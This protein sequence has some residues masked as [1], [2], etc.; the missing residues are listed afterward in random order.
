MVI[1]DTAGQEEYDKLRPIF[2]KDSSVIILC[3][4]IDLPN[5]LTNVIDKWIPELRFYCPQLPII[6]VG[7]KKDLR[8]DAITCRRLKI[9]QHERPCKIEDGE[10]IAQ[11]IRAAYF[12]ECSCKTFENV[13]EIFENAAKLSISSHQINLSNESRKSS[14]TVASLKSS[15]K[16]KPMKI[17]KKKKQCSIL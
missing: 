12:F 14:K 10:I 17:K 6:L 1:Y 3:Y 9:T 7:M 2:Y 16:I 4:S 15:L 5:S 8:N 11:R 13:N